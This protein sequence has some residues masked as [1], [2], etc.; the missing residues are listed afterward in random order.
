[1]R[2]NGRIS[3][4]KIGDKYGRWLVLKKRGRLISSPKRT[5]FRCRCD[6]GTIKLVDAGNLKKPG[7]KS[8]GCLRRENA[9][10]N[11]KKQRTRESYINFLFYTYKRSADK[12]HYI[13]EIDKEAF[14]K[15]IVTNCFYCN[16]APTLKKQARVGLPF[17]TNGIDRIDNN[18]GYNLYNTVSC[19]TICNKM[20]LDT[21]VSNVRDFMQHIVKIK[22]QLPI[23][24]KALGW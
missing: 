24:A 5:L 21:N 14:R 23:V 9:R 3:S 10:K 2:Q 6:C 1:M 12:R 7:N 18:K 15:L 8:C 11:G 19:C 13:F 20:K 4:I 16:S 17:P 22:E